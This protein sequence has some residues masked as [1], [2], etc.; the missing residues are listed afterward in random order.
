MSKMI[1]TDL[2][3]LVAAAVGADDAWRA[4]YVARLKK[5]GDD[6][7]KK[8]TIRNE[9]WVAIMARKLAQNAAGA[10]LTG[11]V[12]KAHFDEALAIL[13]KNDITAKV[14]ARDA[15]ENA[16]YAL[17]RK[18]WSNMLAKAGVEAV[19]K[20]APSPAGSG[21]GKK[22]A[23]PA[24]APSANQSRGVPSENDAKVTAPAPAKS[25]A[26]APATMPLVL[27]AFRDADELVMFMLSEATRLR[28]LFAKNKDCG[29]GDKR[30]DHVRKAC[31]AFLSAMAKVPA[32]R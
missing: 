13:S 1:I 9:A 18:T 24:P 3:T 19:Q 30:A 17:A 26:P 32:K 8:A 14:N 12:T 15:R 10:T 31:E 28:Q 27:P 7:A 5:A 21:K 2:M 25:E 16:L 11:R 6:K 23:A 29:R 22:A 20:R 4:E